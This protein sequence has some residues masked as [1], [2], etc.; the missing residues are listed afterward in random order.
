MG[1]GE[2]MN[3]EERWAG[4]T[5]AREYLDPVDLLAMFPRSGKEH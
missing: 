3:E 1:L 4:A 2:A 5:D